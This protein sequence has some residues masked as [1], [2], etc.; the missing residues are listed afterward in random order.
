MA[1]GQ[2]VELRGGFAM[3]AA[4]TGLPIIPV[5]T[6]SGRVWGRRAFRKRPGCVHIHI[7]EAISLRPSAGGPDPHVEAAMACGLDGGE[8]CG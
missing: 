7:G 6:D 3:I 1:V 4:R 2:D 5:A 8:P